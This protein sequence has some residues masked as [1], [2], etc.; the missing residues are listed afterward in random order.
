MRIIS[1]QALNTWCE[2][3][4]FTLENCLGI[5]SFPSAHIFLGSLK[6]F[7]FSV[8]LLYIFGKKVIF[9]KFPDFRLCIFPEAKE[10]CIHRLLYTKY[11][12][13]IF[14]GQSWFKNLKLLV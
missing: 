4:T 1:N 6:V 7:S 9:L 2:I 3:I 14:T 10:C 13:I 5:P 12:H 8:T 11:R